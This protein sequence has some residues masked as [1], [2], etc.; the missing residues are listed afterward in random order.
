M[1]G[2]TGVMG[3]LAVL[4]G[5]G[6]C[7]GHFETGAGGKQGIRLA[8]GWGRVCRR[9]SFSKISRISALAQVAGESSGGVGGP[10][11]K[12]AGGSAGGVG[13][14]ASKVA[15]GSA[16]NGGTVG[17]VAGRL[18]EQATTTAAILALARGFIG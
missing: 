8:E 5:G 15:G 3:S 1:F 18:C 2:G 17:K 14:P 6:T 7:T 9:T 16:S 10:A 11:S 4:G 12:V 13:G